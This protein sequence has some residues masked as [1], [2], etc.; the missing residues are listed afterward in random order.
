[1]VVPPEVDI[2]DGAPHDLFLTHGVKHG[3]HF[4]RDHFRDLRGTPIG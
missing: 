1:M 2:G 3:H 4:I